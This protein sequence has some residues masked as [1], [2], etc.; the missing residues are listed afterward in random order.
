MIKRD[1]KL[2][3]FLGTSLMF[4]LVVIIFSLT[5]VIKYKK[6][7]AGKSNSASV[8]N[9]EKLSADA[10]VIGKKDNSATDIKAKEKI[11]TDEIKKVKKK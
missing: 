3:F 11:K 1:K 6:S 9:N 2:R 5:L 10:L 7:Y 8:V 4:L